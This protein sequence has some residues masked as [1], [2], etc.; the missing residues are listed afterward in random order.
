LKKA[1]KKYLP[2]TLKSLIINHAN[3]QTIKNHFKKNYS[4]NALLSYILTPFQQDSLAHTNFYEAQSWAKI[5]DELGYNVDIIDF[6]NTKK[7]DLSKYDLICGFGDVFQQYFESGINKKIITI[8]YGAGMHVCHQNQ[9]SLSRVKDVYRKKGVWLAKSARFVEKT[10]THQTA[11][12][13]GIIALGNEVCANSYR[14]YFNGSVYSLP[15]PFYKTIDA[16]TII[17]QKT[18]ESKKHY[19]WFG[20]SGLVHKG[21]DLCLEYFA[22]NQDLYLH[23]CGPIENESNFVTTYN[24]ELFK[25]PNIQVYGFVDIASSEFEN[26]LSKCSFTIFPSC[27]EGGS[28][29][30]LT[31]VG[32]GGLV[33]VITKETTIETGSEIWIDALNYEKINKAIRYSQNLSFEEIKEL[34]YKNIDFVKNNHTQEIY[35]EQ[36][37]K[38]IQNILGQINDL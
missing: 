19:L 35:Y 4:K 17:K 10:W 33:P 32:N 27:S 18:E 30:T 1:L 34:Q 8:Y 29:S 12:V 36:L 28:P 5:L 11:L 16:E 6:R 37:M 9:A 24:K 3:N 7:I 20:S 25:T 13:D 22:K 31:V 38:N 23:V 26:I 21:L 15:A 2:K 14:K